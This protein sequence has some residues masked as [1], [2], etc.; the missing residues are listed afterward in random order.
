M[1][2]KI[3]GKPISRPNKLQDRTPLKFHECGSTSHFA[4]TCPKK[5]RINEIEI[6]KTEDTKEKSDVSVHESDSEP[7]KEELPPQLSIENIIVS[8]EV[9]EV[10]THLT[11]YSDECMHLIHVQDVKMQKIKPSRG[12]AYTSGSSCITNIVIHNKEASINLD[13]GAFFTCV[14]KNYHDKGYTNWKE[15]LVP[16]EG[17]KLRSAN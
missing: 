1:I 6:E 15:K 16:I 14:G 7:S 17:I 13:S 10:H 8:F 11:Q 5:T 12:E 4:N 9:T 2:N 3:I